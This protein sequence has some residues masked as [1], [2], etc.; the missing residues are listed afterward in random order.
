MI[1]KLGDKKIEIFESE[2]KG[3]ICFSLESREQKSILDEKL[4]KLGGAKYD[5]SFNSE[6]VSIDKGKF[7]ELL[8]KEVGSENIIKIVKNISKKDISIEKAKE[9]IQTACTL[10]DFVSMISELKPFFS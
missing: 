5:F 10:K 7:L 6:L 9:W 8:E 2:N 3:K 4:K 1:K